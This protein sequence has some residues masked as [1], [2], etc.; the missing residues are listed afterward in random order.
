[1]FLMIQGCSS[2]PD[3]EKY[4]G[5]DGNFPRLVDV[6]DRP[7]APSQKTID[8]K[9]NHLEQD[10]QESEKLAEQNYQMATK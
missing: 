7:I 4:S 2:T 3:D 8:Q 1:M 10:R 9:M 5:I 6:P